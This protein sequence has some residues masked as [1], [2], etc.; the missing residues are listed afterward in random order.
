MMYRS[1]NRTALILIAL[2]GFLA[3]ASFGARADSWAVVMRDADRSLEIDRTAI[4]PS[5]GGA[6]V[7]WVRL[8]VSPAEAA[9]VG[10][11]TVKALN[12][13]DCTNRGFF[14][15]K[16]VYLDADHFVL[17]EEEVTDR[18]MIA[19]A[20]NSVDER[21][22]REV[23]RPPSVKDLAEVAAQAGSAAAGAK[24]TRREP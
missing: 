21:L 1:A 17:N 16:R 19:V 5:D 14:T 20:R 8:V 6:K 2:G 9:K 12:R 11:T 3:A 13:Y 23:C 18:K 4:I 15:V 7:A 22:W 24:T 10:Y